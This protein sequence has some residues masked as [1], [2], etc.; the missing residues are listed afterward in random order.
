MRS[1]LRLSER[2]LLS[3]PLL[4]KPGLLL[5]AVL[6]RC[7]SEGGHLLVLLVRGVVLMLWDL[8]PMNVP[9]GALVLIESRWGNLL[10]VALRPL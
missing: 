9:A 3:F 8:P 5:G 6:V 1:L 10:L 7:Q 4:C 2:H